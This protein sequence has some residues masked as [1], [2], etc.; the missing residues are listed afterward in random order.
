[1]CNNSDLP[2]V[3]VIVPVRNEEKK[4]NQCLNSIIKQDYPREKFEVLIVDGMSTDKTR[5]IVKK[6]VN[7]NSNF[8][9]MENPKK[10]APSALNIGLINS[11]G[12]III[13]VDGHCYINEDFI[14]KSIKYSIVLSVCFV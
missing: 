13:R 8:K 5:D 4:I 7:C 1:M 9:L 6:Y 2:F 14:S 3:Q 10:I 12:D 11:K